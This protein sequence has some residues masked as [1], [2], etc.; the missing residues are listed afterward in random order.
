LLICI[1]N[2]YLIASPAG[3]IESFTIGR[4]Q[5]GLS[6]TSKRMPA[7]HTFRAGIHDVKR[8][9]FLCNCIQSVLSFVESNTCNG[10]SFGPG[11][12]QRYRISIYKPLLLYFIFYDDIIISP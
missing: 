5:T 6:F 3:G 1:K 8:I 9:V 2:N 11:F 7:N 4:K 10:Y 12:A